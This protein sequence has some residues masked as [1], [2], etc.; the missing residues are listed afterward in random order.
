MKK[1]IL[2]ILMV[3]PLFL[4]ATTIEDSISI[5]IATK[6]SGADKIITTTLGTTIIEADYTFEDNAYNI[7]KAIYES[8]NIFTCSDWIESE[9]YE[10]CWSRYY[11]YFKEDVKYFIGITIDLGISHRVYIIVSELNS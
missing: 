4:N 3:V 11:I 9:N 5:E 2:L 6:I 8:K 10:R 1:I 7:V